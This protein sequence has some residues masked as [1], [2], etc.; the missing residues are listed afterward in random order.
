MLAFIYSKWFVN[1]LV[2]NMN[3][4]YKYNSFNFSITKYSNHVVLH[5]E[6][7]LKQFIF[8][9]ILNCSFK[10]FMV[11]RMNNRLWWCRRSGRIFDCVGF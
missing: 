10:E 6:K 4:I 2:K 9:V 3:V 11:E 7:L 5:V 8:F 1:S